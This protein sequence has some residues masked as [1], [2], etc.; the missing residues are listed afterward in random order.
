MTYSHN[1]ILSCGV[2]AVAGNRKVHWQSTAAENETK[3]LLINGSRGKI[4]DEAALD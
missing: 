3:R 2:A 1:L 4:V